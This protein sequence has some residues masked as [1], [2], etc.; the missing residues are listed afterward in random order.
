MPRPSNSTN[1]TGHVWTETR[2]LKLCVLAIKQSECQPS[3]LADLWV[4][5]Y[6]RLLLDK[7]N[8]A[9]LSR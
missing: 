5:A 2:M 8:Q 7:F 3:L 9:F 4:A 1:P 6:R